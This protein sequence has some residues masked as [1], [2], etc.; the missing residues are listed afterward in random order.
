MATKNAMQ[1]YTTLLLSLVAVSL[2]SQTEETRLIDSFPTIQLG[3][4]A[5]ATDNQTGAFSHLGHQQFNGGIIS[6]PSLLIQGKLSGVQIYN[7]GGDPN[8]SPFARSRYFLHH[9][10]QCFGGN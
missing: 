4:A 9:P 6:D 1:F 5:L 7:R 3:Y 2:F 8:V 10:I